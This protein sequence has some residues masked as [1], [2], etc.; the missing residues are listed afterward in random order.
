M[1]DGARERCALRG[2]A[3][4]CRPNFRISRRDGRVGGRRREVRQ[5]A[6]AGRREAFGCET[7]DA[8][9]LGASGALR[10]VRRGEHLPLGV[11]RLLR[12]IPLGLGGE[13]LRALGSKDRVDPLL[14]GVLPC[15]VC[16][17]SLNGGFQTRLQASQSIGVVVDE[18]GDQ[19]TLRDLLP[20]C[21]VPARDAPADGGLE[22]LG[23][24][25]GR[26]GDDAARAS[27]VLLPRSDG[28]ETR[29]EKE[30]QGETLSD[31]TWTRERGHSPGDRQEDLGLRPHRASQALEVGRLHD[32]TPCST[33][34]RP[35]VGTR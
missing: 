34:T 2:E 23:S 1:G 18:L 33:M 16:V 13:H 29:E 4:L 19:I 32:G 22:R 10:G 15:T 26:E 9:A 35:S 17:S 5:L 27:E 7:F 31:P 25:V 14:V 20:F 28:G 21:H 24:L 3:R 12:D 8:V 11:E 6:V 30:T